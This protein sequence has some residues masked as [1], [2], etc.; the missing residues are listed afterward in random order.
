MEKLT[1]SCICHKCKKEMRPTITIRDARVKF[2]V[3]R[4]CDNCGSVRDYRQ[5]LQVEKKDGSLVPLVLDIEGLQEES[6]GVVLPPPHL[7]ST[8]LPKDFDSATISSRVSGL[9]ESEFR[10]SCDTCFFLGKAT[11][12]SARIYD[13]YHCTRDPQTVVARF[14]NR[15]NDYISGPYTK[16]PAIALAVFLAVKSGRGCESL[17]RAKRFIEYMDDTPAHGLYSI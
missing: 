2:S 17:G 8:G 4:V 16:H 14:G 6:E 1:L 9:V 15:Q 12:V 11:S 7:F 3:S 10:H 13:L 5:L